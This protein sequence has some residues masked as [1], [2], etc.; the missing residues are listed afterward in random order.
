MPRIKLFALKLYFKY[1]HHFCMMSKC[2]SKADINFYSFVFYRHLFITFILVVRPVPN[3][4]FLFNCSLKHVINK[5]NLNEMILFLVKAEGD[6]LKPKFC[7][8]RTVITD[9]TRLQWTRKMNCLC[10]TTV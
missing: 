6:C 9:R 8:G 3:Q 2:N 4:F 1:L 5:T 10:L 7:T